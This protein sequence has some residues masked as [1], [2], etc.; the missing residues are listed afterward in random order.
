MG[1]NFKN[2]D[3]SWAYSGFNRFR[4]RLADEVGIDL[5]KMKGFQPLELNDEQGLEWDKKA[6]DWNTVKNP[7]K[8]FL[9][10]S[11]CDGQISAKKCGTIAE[12]INNIV[13]KWDKD[14]YDTRQANELVKTMRNCFKNNKPLIFI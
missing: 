10:H 3:A 6:I 1:I 11:D 9:N 14:D 7:L 12:I 2:S 4:E 8:P 13:S 5:R